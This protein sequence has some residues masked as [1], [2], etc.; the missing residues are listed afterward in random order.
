MGP[1]RRTLTCHPRRPPNRR[2]PFTAFGLSE[3]LFSRHRMPRSLSPQHQAPPTESRPHEC[4]VEIETLLR[5]GWPGTERMPHFGSPVSPFTLAPQQRRITL[6]SR[7]Q[8]RRPAPS[9]RQRPWPP[10]TAPSRRPDSATGR[11]RTRSRPSKE[12]GTVH[13]R[14][15]VAVADISPLNLTW[16]ATAVGA[17]RVIRVPSPSCPTSFAPQQ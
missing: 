2:L 9:W 13:V 7:M 10:A 16:P 12:R 3:P 15:Q 11:S 1:P 8:P 17:A 6:L 14:P 4:V 5:G